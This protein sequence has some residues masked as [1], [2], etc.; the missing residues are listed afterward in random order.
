MRVRN[1]DMLIIFWIL[2]DYYGL[3][4]GGFDFEQYMCRACGDEKVLYFLTKTVKGL[5]NEGIQETQ[6]ESSNNF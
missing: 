1:G 3:T 4:A 5:V 2:K 6:F